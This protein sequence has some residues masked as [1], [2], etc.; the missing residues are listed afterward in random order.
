MTEVPFSG[1]GFIHLRDRDM[2]TTVSTSVRTG[3]RADDAITA[4]IESARQ[5]VKHLDIDLLR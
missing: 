5:A 3:D 1:S 2:L 4:R